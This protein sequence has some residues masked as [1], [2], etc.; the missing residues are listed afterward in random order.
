VPS[1]SHSSWGARIST[2][3]MPAPAAP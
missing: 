1:C 2:G 3:L